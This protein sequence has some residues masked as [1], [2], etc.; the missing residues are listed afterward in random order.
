MPATTAFQLDAMVIGGGIAGLWTLDE[1]SRR[2]LVCALVE[3]DALGAGQTVW[4]Q[5]I[6]HGGL[7]YTLGG[8]MNPSAEAI[9][10]MPTL[11]R[12]CLAGAREPNLAD[13][14]VRASHCHLWQ[15]GSLASRLGMIGARAGLRVAPV[16][17]GSEDRPALLRECPGV[18]ARLDEQV[19]DPA[20]VLR[21][22][23]ERNAGRVVRGE[24]D[25]VE[26]HGDG[27][28]VRVTGA[29]DFLGESA[30]REQETRSLTV[31]V[32][33]L[34]LCAG[35][36]NA[37]LREM[38]RLGAGRVQVRPLRM[39]MVRGSVLPELNGHCVDGAKT[40][41]TITTARDA[42]GRAV[43]QVGGEV[44]ERGVS[45]SANELI[46]F[47]QAELLAVLPGV[48]LSECEWATYDAPRAEAAMPGNRRPDD[49][50]VIEDG[51]VLTVFPTKLA[52]APRVAEIVASL[53]CDSSVSMGAAC[54]DGW[55]RPAVAK[56]P[57]ESAVWSSLG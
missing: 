9:R 5:G 35:N 16:V 45:M 57:W 50:V 8:L 51:C 24:L 22:L 23:A 37:A 40:R 27:A 25:A 32:R 56:G 12:R 42:A 19:I 15:T 1:L 39:V 55:E 4:S 33:W 43:W 21:V 44:A 7:K 46:R 38:M 30:A 17:L 54:F 18:V 36:G 14:G 28:R 2:G 6:I 10:G 34:V 13:A 47:A 20:A 3:R 49:A 11:W 41:V 53:V 26:I 31:G 48:D 52:L 29:T